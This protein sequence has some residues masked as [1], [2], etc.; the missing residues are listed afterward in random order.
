MI[1]KINYKDENDDAD[2]DA[3][4]GDADVPE[5]EEQAPKLTWT[6][7]PEAM[8][9]TLQ[10]KGRFRATVLDQKEATFDISDYLWYM[11]R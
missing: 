8:R 11:T 7:A 9:D 10:G 6:W 4:E 2:D 1:K 5:T 3:N